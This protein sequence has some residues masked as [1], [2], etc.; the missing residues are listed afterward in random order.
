[1]QNDFTSNKISLPFPIYWFSRLVS[2]IPES[3][4]PVPLGAFPLRLLHASA[5]VSIFVHDNLFFSQCIRDMFTHY[6]LL[7]V[8]FSSIRNSVR[9]PSVS[10]DLPTVVTRAQVLF[11][12]PECLFSRHNLRSLVQILPCVIAVPFRLFFRRGANMNLVN[13]SLVQFES[14]V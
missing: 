2:L 6:L 11:S 3:V 10:R 9:S 5:L 12:P 13:D 14:S 7:Q 8:T 1:M 4:P